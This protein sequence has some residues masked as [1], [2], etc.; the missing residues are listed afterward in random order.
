MVYP[1]KVVGASLAS[2][3]FSG[4]ERSANRFAMVNGKTLMSVSLNVLENSVS[5]SSLADFRLEKNQS[6]PPS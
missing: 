1:V 3:S 5:N 2:L 6:L 4:S